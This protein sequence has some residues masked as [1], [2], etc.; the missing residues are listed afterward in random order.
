MDT[1]IEAHTLNNQSIS[2][3]VVAT[4]A[5]SAIATEA[6]NETLLELIFPDGINLRCLICDDEKCFGK[7]KIV[8]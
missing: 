4:T 5:A 6:F 2:A 1:T 8:G 3:A 7:H